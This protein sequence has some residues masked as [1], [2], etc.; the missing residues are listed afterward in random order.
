MSNPPILEVSDVSLRFG[1]IKA[2]DGVSFQVKK[3]SIAGLIGPNGSG[4]TSLFNVITGFYRHGAGDVRLDGHKIMNA[5]PHRIA[6]IG[7]SRTFQTAALQLDRTV[8]ENVMLGAYCKRSDLWKDIFGMHR[9]RADRERALELLKSFGLIGLADQQARALP[10]GLRHVVEL[11]R[12]MMTDPKFLLMDEAWGGLNS[13]EARNL[14]EVISRIRD[15]GVTVFLVEH[16]IKVIMTICEQVVVLNA[17]KKIADGT[18]AEVR[19]DPAVVESYL[20]TQEY[21]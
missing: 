11:A 12:S 17:G 20:G 4:K 3:G 5:P 2:L 9:D 16:N 7:L 15:R 1:G 8:L 13:A 14:S 18:P 21:D 19:T 10:A 6:R